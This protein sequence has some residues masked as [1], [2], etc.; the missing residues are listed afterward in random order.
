MGIRLLTYNE[1]LQAQMMGELFEDSIEKSSLSSPLFIRYFMN[2]EVSLLYKDLIHQFTSMTNL[3]II[4]IVEK[5]K[6]IRKKGVVF[7]KD[8]MH[9]IGYCYL[10]MVRLNETSPKYIY[11]LFPAMKMWNYYPI[12]H[13]FSIESAVDRM[14]E[15]N[16]MKVMT[17]REREKI[18]LAES[19]KKQGI[20]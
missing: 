1:M 19:L 3:E 7:T 11:K 8:E 20:L 4:E 10:A 12:Y 6:K 5:G 16:G 13:T 17:L 2:S 15:E 9:W 14:F 18:V